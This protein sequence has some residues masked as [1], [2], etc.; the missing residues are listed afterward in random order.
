LL[1]QKI[2]KA[3]LIIAG[4]PPEKIPSYGQCIPGVRFTGFVEDLDGLYRKSRVVCAPILWGGGTRFK[5]I[6]AASYCKP[7][8]STLIGAEGLE[9][10]D[11]FG[12]F[13][14][15]TPK[16]FAEK[17]IQLLSDHEFCERMGAAARAAIIDK[18]DQKKIRPMIQEYFTIDG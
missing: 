16:T 3:N 11:G 18:Y 6:E 8:V 14:R 7:I 15:D 9:M 5:I 10:Q 1:Q 12:I 2:P 4:N 17:C 13:L